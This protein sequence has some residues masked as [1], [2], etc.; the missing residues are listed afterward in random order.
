M[1]TYRYFEY[2][3]THLCVFCV[4]SVQYFE[5]HTT[6]IQRRQS[7]TYED[8]SVPL[9]KDRKALT[10]VDLEGSIGADMGKTIV[11]GR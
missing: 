3:C 7:F 10:Q 9:F 11:S 5:V 6:Y 1:H 2:T 8:G 4:Y